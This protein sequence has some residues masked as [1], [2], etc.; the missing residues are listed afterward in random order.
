M[1]NKANWTILTYIAAHNSLEAFGKASLAQVIGVG[2]TPE[3]VHGVLFD[4]A[5]GA[6]RYIVGDPGKVLVAQHTPDFDCGDPDNLVKT[7]QWL[8]QAY[9]AE[10]YGL[11]LWSHGTGWRPEE[12]EALSK[13]A[14]PKR[15]AG[16]DA[17]RSAAP[18][19]RVVFRTSLAKLL[20][21]ELPAERAVLFD[22]GSGHSLDTLELEQVLAGI[23]E[24]TGKAL[25]VLGMDACL[26]AN[27]ELAYQIR[28]HVGCLVASE[29]PVP[30][31]SWPY[32]LIY[33]ELQSK[34]HMDGRALAG[35]F[36]RQ[37]LEY[38][39][40]H[41]PK[42][43]DV[44]IVALD[45]ANINKL[46]EPVDALSQSLLANLSQD[47]DCLWKAQ[48]QARHKEARQ[49]DDLEDQRV[50]NKFLLHLWDIRSLAVGLAAAGA[51]AG[52]QAAAGQVCDALAP[53]G[54]FVLA[55]GHRGDW[56]EGVGGVSL[57]FPPASASRISP[58]YADLSFAQTTTW[59]NLLEAYR[60]HYA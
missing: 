36:A 17:E 52:V 56:F 39:T 34:P 41:P 32:D 14:Y 42:A 11:V 21:P 3:V 37:Y 35:C 24:V 53:G 19:S 4:G 50:P 12:I 31:S 57:Y 33:A 43:G 25:D 1:P 38:Y 51:S 49:N 58:Y 5:G 59:K 44:T 20:Q 40:A 48:V 26:M 10:R 23:Q 18:G 47:A 55:E 29:E 15:A 7:A 45:L 30:G 16:E 8:F 60:A 22:D 6:E 27:L 9:P 13:A 46:V 54:P 28:Q 2:S